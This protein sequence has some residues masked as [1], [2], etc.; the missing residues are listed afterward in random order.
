MAFGVFVHRSDSIYNDSLAESYRFPLQ[1]LTRVEQ[2]LGDWIVYLESRKVRN[3]CGYFAAAK[4]ETIIPDP[5]GPDM[6]LATWDR[7]S[8]NNLRWALNQQGPV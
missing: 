2:C 4:A 3:S 7:L 5:I 6:F 1:Y 8:A